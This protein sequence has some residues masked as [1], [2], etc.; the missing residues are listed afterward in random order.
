[1]KS[2]SEPDQ[3]IWNHVQALFQLREA[4]KQDASQ[5]D[6][7]AHTVKI[8]EVE[9]LIC[10][11]LSAQVRPIVFAITHDRVP[12]DLLKEVANEAVYKMFNS[13]AGLKEKASLRTYFGMIVKTVAI[14]CLKKISKERNLFAPVEEDLVN[15]ADEPTLRGYLEKEKPGRSEDLSSRFADN[16]FDLIDF[17]GQNLTG[18][19]FVAVMLRLAATLTQE[20]LTD[21]ELA[22]RLG[23]KRTTLSGLL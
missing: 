3:T 14:G 19:E 10:E 7:Y 9:S 4:L 2:T 1:M 8:E 22:R 15:A 12:E 11:R 20:S 6:S 18:K 21:E 16:I 23:M 17:K 5:E 13:Y